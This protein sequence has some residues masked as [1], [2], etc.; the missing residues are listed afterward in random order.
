VATG[1]ESNLV[2]IWDP[3]A[4]RAEL[5]QLGLD[6]D[7]PDYPPA[8]P[9][10]AP[11][12]LRVAVGGGALFRR[13]GQR[14]KRPKPP[15]GRNPFMKWLPSSRKVGARRKRHRAA[16]VNGGSR[17]EETQPAEES[18]AQVVNSPGASVRGGSPASP[19]EP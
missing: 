15:P 10:K 16:T 17:G 11:E 4:L 6:W 2:Y 14:L 12:P 18:L 5:K 3:R 7:Q 19:D 1:Q 8:P 13:G 9:G